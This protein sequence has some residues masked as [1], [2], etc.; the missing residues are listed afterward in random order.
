MRPARSATNTRALSPGGE[1]AQ[2]GCENV[3][4]ETSEGAAAAGAAS[5]NTSKSVIPASRTGPDHPRIRTVRVTVRVLPAAS[6]AL[7][8]SATGSDDFRRNAARTART[9]RAVSFT[10]TTSRFPATTDAVVRRNCATP[11][12]EARTVARQASS[13]RSVSESRFS[14][15]TLRTPLTAS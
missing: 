7:T 13:V 9:P 1:P 12:I 8:R 2:T 14:R 10:R 3:P 6:T 5:T 15:R 4:S 11:L